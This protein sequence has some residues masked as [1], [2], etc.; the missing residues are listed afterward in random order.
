MK[1]I[2]LLAIV[3]LSTIATFAQKNGGNPHKEKS[4]LVLYTCPMHADVITTHD[5]VCA[6]CSSKLIVDRRGSKQLVKVYTCSM[7][8]QVVSNEKGKCPICGQPLDKENTSK[9][10]TNRKS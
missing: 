10:S 7:H 6:K 2:T 9:E 3:L 8:E 5:G 4:T 1:K